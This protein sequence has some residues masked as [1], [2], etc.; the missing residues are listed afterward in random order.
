MSST[1]LSS[2]PDRVIAKDRQMLIGPPVDSNPGS[3]SSTPSSPPTA[4]S[5]TLGDITPTK[6]RIAVGNGSIW[7][8]LDVGP[9][10][11]VLTVDP[12]TPTGLSWGL[13][14]SPVLYQFDER[15]LWTYGPDDP[16]FTDEWILNIVI[17]DPWLFEDLS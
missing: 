7:T 15:D 9:V 12:T 10:G 3:G 16:D 2:N 11:Y 14:S 6:G 13:A 17:P 5:D 8:F 1:G 4:D